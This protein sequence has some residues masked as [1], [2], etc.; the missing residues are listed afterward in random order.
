MMGVSPAELDALEI[1]QVAA[2]LG[3]ADPPE[4]EEGTEAA[5]AT[6]SASRP[7]QGLSPARR[8]GRAMLKARVKAAEE[9]RPS[10][11]WGPPTAAE[12]AAMSPLLTHGLIGR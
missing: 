5:P 11:R 8:A 7:E 12:Q 9:G 10:P 4:V 3:H 2:V 1:W 6:A